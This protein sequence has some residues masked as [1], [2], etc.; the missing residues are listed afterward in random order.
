M[1]L[2]T[3][4]GLDEREVHGDAE[5]EALDNGVEVWWSKGEFLSKRPESELLGVHGAEL[6][7]GTKGSTCNIYKYF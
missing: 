3:N 5:R 2:N 1:S 4:I 6:H 7:P